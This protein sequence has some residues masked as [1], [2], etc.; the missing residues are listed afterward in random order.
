MPRISHF[1]QSGAGLDPMHYQTGP[2]PKNA[3]APL[4]KCPMSILLLSS[5][6]VFPDRKYIGKSAE[7][8]DFCPMEDIHSGCNF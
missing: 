1:N 8:A 4:M 7:F 6:L 2:N 5:V 3:P